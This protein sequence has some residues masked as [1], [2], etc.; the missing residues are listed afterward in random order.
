MNM[1]TIINWNE[2]KI[3]MK[4]LYSKSILLPLI[5][6]FSFILSACHS[7]STPQIP[8]PSQHS[9]SSSQELYTD[10][11]QSF[12]QHTSDSTSTSQ[13]TQSTLNLSE[14]PPLSQEDMEIAVP[15]FLT[16][17]QQML[18]RRAYCFYKC[19]RKESA[20][21][22]DFHAIDETSLDKADTQYIEIEGKRY[23]E[24]MGRYKN[25]T[26]F[27]SII[28]SVFTPE[29]VEKLNITNDMGT[30]YIEVDNTLYYQDIS[31]MSDDRLENNYEFVLKT[32]TDHKIGFQLLAHY[33]NYQ[34]ALDSSVVDGIVSEGDKFTRAFDMEI[35]CDESGQWRFSQFEIPF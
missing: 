31:F 32:S 13:Q 3:Y 33:S 6:L 2:R 16:D 10:G 7:T 29:L 30:V 15:D 11:E 9:S 12:I 21:I 14:E 19:F 17:E 5:L 1:S 8:A 26:F 23:Y 28:N 22:D 34:Y 24:S 25:W 27:S 35:V 20:R 4:F 18:Y